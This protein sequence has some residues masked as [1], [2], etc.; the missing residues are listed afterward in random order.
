MK[1]V[2]ARRLGGFTLIELLVVV[3]IIGILAAVALPQYQLA[4]DKAEWSSFTPTMK[5]VMDAQQR[6]YM[7]N[8]QYAEDLDDLDIKV[9]FKG[10]NRPYVYAA[11]SEL[12]FEPRG[13]TRYQYRLD[14]RTQKAY[15]CA[16]VDNKRYIRLCQ[17]V[18]GLDTPEKTASFYEWYPVA[19]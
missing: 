14:Y 17:A 10:I 19:N 7:A 5:A 2:T 13:A 3:L 11:K 1:N 8:N 16:F 4:V 9:N 18:S 15:C 12:Y 6:Y